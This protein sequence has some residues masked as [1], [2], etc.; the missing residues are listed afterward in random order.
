[1]RFTYNV[2]I[3]RRKWLALREPSREASSGTF[4]IL[5]GTLKVF[6]FQCIER[7][8]NLPAIRRPLR[9]RARSILQNQRAIEI[10]CA[11]YTV[12]A[13]FGTAALRQAIES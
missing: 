8:A 5:L 11:E 10:R 7:R 13:D 6:V 1:M 9:V 2:L 12:F 4:V 3:P